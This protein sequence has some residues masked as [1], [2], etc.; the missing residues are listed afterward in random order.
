MI[1]QVGHAQVLCKVC[2]KCGVKK[3]TGEFYRHVH[4][5]DRLRPEC[6]TCHVRLREERRKKKIENHRAYCRNYKKRPNVRERLNDYRRLKRRMRKDAEA[7]KRFG[8][9]TERSLWLVIG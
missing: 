7:R 4:T 9:E 6:K 1:L 3:P 5:R 8:M 2:S